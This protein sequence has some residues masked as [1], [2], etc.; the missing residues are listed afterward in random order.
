MNTT[1]FLNCVAGNLFQSKTDPA[2]PAE[3]YVG[4]STTSPA[5]DGTGVT[6]P[7]SDP[8]YSRAKITSLTEPING[9]VTNASAIGFNESTIDWGTITHYA[10]YDTVSEGNLLMFGPLERERRVEEATIMTIKA[11]TLTLSVLNP[12]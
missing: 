2:L 1:Y 5:I 6:E 3:Y 11:G 10:I 8:D 12:A 4:L 7:T 9:M